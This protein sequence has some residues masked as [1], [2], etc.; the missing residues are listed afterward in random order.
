MSRC[1]DWS[2]QRAASACAQPRSN[3]TPTTEQS[4][5]CETL[6]AVVFSSRRTLKRLRSGGRR[7]S[8]RASA[9]GDA[10]ATEATEAERLMP[11]VASADRLR[12]AQVDRVFDSLREPPPGCLGGALRMKIDRLSKALRPAREVV[13]LET[14][15]RSGPLVVATLPARGTVS[16]AVWRR[17]ASASF[18]RALGGE[19]GEL[20]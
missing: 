7:R 16:N 11:L 13:L 14:L 20:G 8:P 6:L 3:P 19:G 1:S 2:K 4:R 5:C 12:R 9:R 17:K 15:D 18:L 10:L